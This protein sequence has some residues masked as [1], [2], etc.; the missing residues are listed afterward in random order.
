MEEGNHA[1]NEFNRRNVI[2]FQISIK[3]SNPTP[4]MEL[5][6]KHFQPDDY[7]TN[8]NKYNKSLGYI[9]CIFL[10]SLPCTFLYKELLI[11]SHN[12]NIRERTYKS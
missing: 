1:A 12:L 2:L 4:T 8:T 10:K 7:M 5:C 11:R 3:K 6:E 9:H